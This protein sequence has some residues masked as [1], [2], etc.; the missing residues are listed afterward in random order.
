MDSSDPDIPR[1][2]ATDQG[3]PRRLPKDGG[4][5]PKARRALL[6]GLAFLVPVGLVVAGAPGPLQAPLN[7]YDGGLLLTLARFTNWDLLPYRD[8]WTLYGPGPPVFGS[9]IMRL[10]GSGTLPIR[11]GYLVLH[12]LLVMG[13][14]VVSKRFVPPWV[15]AVLA[16]PVAT[17][18]YSPNHFHFAI[19]VAVILWGLW[20][21][22]R[23]GNRE[24][25]SVRM[26]AMGALLVGAAF[27]GRYEFALVGALCAVGLWA[28]LRPRLGSRGWVV[29][30]VGLLPG[31]LFLVYL[32]GVVGLE[33]AWL[34]LV[35]YPLT[36]YPRPSCRGLGPV[37]GN[38]L[39]AFGA[40]F[41]GR[42]WT[43]AELTLW[44]NTF[45]A[46]VIGIWA[47]LVGVRARNERSPRAFAAL[48]LGS[49]CLV[50]W[51]EMRGRAAGEPHPV[52]YSLIPS[53]AVV[54]SELS[55]LG[56]RIRNGILAGSGGVFA[57]T[58]L[59][60]WVPPVLPLWRTWPD[61]HARYGFARVEKDAIF[62]HE[63][64]SEVVGVVH[65]HARPEEPIFVAL[66]VNTAHEANLPI[67]YW[68]TDRPPASRF[69]EF[70]PCLT[71]TSEV[72]HTIVRDIDN[73]NVVVAS[74]YYFRPSAPKGPPST[75]LDDYL[76]RNFTP[77]YRA[78][79]L[80]PD[81]Y[82]VLLRTEDGAAR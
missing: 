30:V 16:I 82:V 56:P 48:A 42:L 78:S 9:F 20:F 22:L 59:L 50:L 5:T 36:E 65:R 55:T 10:F 13:V 40:S 74:P 76:T 33:R 46:P 47:V 60:F 79:V 54:G 51:L 71:D 26:V 11:L 2:L 57:A 41:T 38:A 66:T 1:I 44:V 43:G 73:A 45:I 49:L 64:W 61:Y 72:Q 67:F 4:R 81:D 69:I 21:V 24:R 14:Y 17:F 58:M 75:V 28:F 12:L 39:R 80:F 77:V 53:L 32:L 52:W 62:D 3:S 8:L 23:A 7:P 18:G 6:N 34:N 37:W 19:S 35:D 25:L 68:L 31:I 27:W 29:L 15:A 63:V 70:D